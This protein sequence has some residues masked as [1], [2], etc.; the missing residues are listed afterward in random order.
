MIV[1]RKQFGRAKGGPIAGPVLSLIKIM[2]SDMVLAAVSSNLVYILALQFE[3]GEGG[4][5]L[6]HKIRA[7]TVFH[8]NISNIFLEE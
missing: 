4:A 5:Q 1:I 8:S 2:G 7:S 3:V 6:L